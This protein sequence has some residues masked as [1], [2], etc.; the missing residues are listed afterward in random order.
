[1]PPMV[2]RPEITVRSP[3]STAPASEPDTPVACP[4]RSADEIH[5]QSEVQTREE[6]APPVERAPQA[7]LGD[8]RQHPSRTAAGA[9]TVREPARGA[10]QQASEPAPTFVPPAVEPVVS[11]PA[12]SEDRPRRSGWWSKR[13][14]GKD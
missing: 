12:E 14:L 4:S 6:P 3:I 11:S 13:A 8:D 2:S 7:P 1:L 9:S 10:A 5:R